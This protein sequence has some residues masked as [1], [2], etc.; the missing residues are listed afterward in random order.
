MRVVLERAGVRNAFGKQVRGNNVL[1]NAKAAILAMRQLREPRRY[2][3][4]LGVT[5]DHLY[6]RDLSNPAVEHETDEVQDH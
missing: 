2:A 4:R 6:G 1:N 5:V 3:R